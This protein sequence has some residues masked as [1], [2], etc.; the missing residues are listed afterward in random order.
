MCTV[1]PPAAP[2]PINPDKLPVV[3]SVVYR[4]FSS[5]DQLPRYSPFRHT[6]AECRRVTDGARTRDLRSHNPMLCQLSYGHQA[7]TR[8]YQE[9]V[10]LGRWLGAPSQELGLLV[11]LL[12][13]VHDLEDPGGRGV[14]Y[15][16][17]VA[18]GVVDLDGDAE[19]VA[20]LVLVGDLEGGLDRGVLLV[21]PVAPQLQG[22]VGVET[23]RP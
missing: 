16:C 13:L 9:K 19:V 1:L 15:H 7:R 11:V 20:G 21:L 5:C 2:A 22:D 8:F 6:Y 14:V 4:A 10:T 3:Y 12:A 17:H 18:V 23:P